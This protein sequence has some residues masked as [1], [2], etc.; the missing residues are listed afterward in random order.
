MPYFLY[1][2][3]VPIL[4]SLFFFNRKLQI[5][6]QSP[7]HPVLFRSICISHIQIVVFPCTPIL[8][9]IFIQH[10]TDFCFYELQKWLHA[11]ISSRNL[12]FHPTL[13]LRF[14]LV[15]TCKSSPFVLTSVQCPVKWKYILHP[16]SPHW[17]IYELSPVSCCCQCCNGHHT[18]VENIILS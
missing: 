5:L 14:I 17:R 8:S 3:H 9:H 11:Y 16:Y 7:L 1:F 13:F 12:L 10:C 15:S 2:F 6:L 18:W 4:F